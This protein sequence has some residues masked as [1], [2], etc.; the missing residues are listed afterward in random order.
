MRQL[1]AELQ[2]T[3]AELLTVKAQLRDARIAV[4]D[5]TQKID[6]MRRSAFWR[7]RELWVKLRGRT[8]S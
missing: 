5:G 4:L 1:D 3:V 7:A 8:S 2:R 6:A